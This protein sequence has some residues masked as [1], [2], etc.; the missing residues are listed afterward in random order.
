MAC[1]Q[2]NACLSPA[3][4]DARKRMSRPHS[5]MAAH[6]LGYL[7]NETRLLVQ[8]GFVFFR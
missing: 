4:S 2:N 1:P 8:T 3:C 5:D 6:I 7:K